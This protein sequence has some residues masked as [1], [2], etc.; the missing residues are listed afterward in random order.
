MP[1]I[2]MS[3]Y[4]YSGRLLNAGTWP[5]NAYDAGLQ[6][7]CGER[8]DEVTFW[9]IHVCEWFISFSPPNFV[10]IRFYAHLFFLACRY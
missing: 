4:Y 8:W 9:L 6:T 2:G 7:L 3:G 5:S 1:F 10:L